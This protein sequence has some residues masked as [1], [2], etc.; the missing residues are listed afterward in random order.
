MR[1]DYVTMVRALGGEP[2]ALEAVEVSDVVEDRAE[3]PQ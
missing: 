1:F 3:Y 2:S